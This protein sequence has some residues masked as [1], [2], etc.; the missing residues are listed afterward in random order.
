[1][2]K[3]TQNATDSGFQV[4]CCDAYVLDDVI[5]KMYLELWIG[6]LIRSASSWVG[7]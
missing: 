1:M 3:N 7:R 4:V 2:E 6:T 5:D